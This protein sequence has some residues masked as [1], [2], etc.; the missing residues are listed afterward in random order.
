MH[1]ISQYLLTEKT[2]NKKKKGIVKENQIN[3]KSSTKSLQKKNKKK[4]IK[5][6]N[7]EKKNRYTL[8]FNEKPE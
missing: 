1:Y 3:S 4:I 8:N 5:T 6:L 7:T 2:N